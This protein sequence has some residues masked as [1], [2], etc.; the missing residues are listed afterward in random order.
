[1]IDRAY[2]TLSAVCERVVVVGG[3]G[4]HPTYPTV[5]DRSPGIG[6]FGGASRAALYE[7][8]RVG[9]VGVGSARL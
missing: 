9:A 8:R 5:A 3:P 4:A 6:P 2:E 1:M 7:A